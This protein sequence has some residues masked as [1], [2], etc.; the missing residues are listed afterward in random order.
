MEKGVSEIVCNKNDWLT[1][2]FNRISNNS[3]RTGSEFWNQP[4]LIGD[5]ETGIHVSLT[6]TQR[7]LASPL[8]LV[9]RPDI[10][11]E[12]TTFRDNQPP[13]ANYPWD[14]SKYLEK[15]LETLKPL[16]KEQI[17]GHMPKFDQLQVVGQNPL[18]QSNKNRPKKSSK[19]ESVLTDQNEYMI[20]NTWINQNIIDNDKNQSD[21]ININNPYYV[22][23]DNSNYEDALSS[24]PDVIQPPIFGPCIVFG[25]QTARWNGSSNENVGV[26][27]L[28]SRLNFETKAGRRVLATFEI[29]NIGTSTIYYDWKVCVLIKKKE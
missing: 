26:T 21:I 4:H 11:L 27:A 19:S 9:S 23:I 3:D 16:I 24:H 25:G 28:E 12:E 20:N 1:F 29:I 18:I 2:D 13:V 8:E 10:I 5:A 14:K 17:G 22:N 6:K 15:R 7:G